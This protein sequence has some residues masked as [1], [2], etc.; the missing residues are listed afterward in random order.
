M[1]SLWSSQYFCLSNISSKGAEIHAVSWKRY[2]I[3]CANSEA[4]EPYAHLKNDYCASYREFWRYIKQTNVQNCMV[5]CGCMLTG[6]VLWSLRHMGQ[7]RQRYC[8]SR[9]FFHLLGDVYY[10]HGFQDVT[11][12]LIL[13]S[14]CMNTRKWGNLSLFLFRCSNCACPNY[15]MH[16][17]SL[18]SASVVRQRKIKC[19]GTHRSS[20][21]SISSNT[22]WQL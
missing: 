12:M 22:I 2:R 16:M 15:T 11:R 19:L 13:V 21:I 1:R 5:W 3:T 18:T 4:F 17:R 10:V 9:I 8:R 7:L 20:L 6:C 14:F